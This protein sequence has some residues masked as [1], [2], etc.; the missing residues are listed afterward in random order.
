MTTI[1][2][3]TSIKSSISFYSK[4]KSLSEYGSKINKSYLLTSW[5]E[6][7]KLM[8]HFQGEEGLLHRSIRRVK[9]LKRTL[10]SLPKTILI[11]PYTP[12]HDVNVTSIINNTRTHILIF[13][14]KTNLP[15]DLYLRG[16]GIDMVFS[17]HTTCFG[18]NP[19]LFLLLTHSNYYY[20]TY[21]LTLP[22]RKITSLSFLLII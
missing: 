5:R 14:Y 22:L 10:Y 11:S 12:L 8:L 7:N 2:P 18:Q 16:K 19:H 15:F 20:N 3:T 17:F 21:H 13:L 4:S 6:R 9:S 1:T